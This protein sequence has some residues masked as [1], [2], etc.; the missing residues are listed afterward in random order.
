MS[1]PIF[2]SSAEIGKPNTKRFPLIPIGESTL[3]DMTTYSE[4]VNFI[5]GTAIDAGLVPPSQFAFVAGQI[6]YRDQHVEEVRL[7]CLVLTPA[8]QP[9]RWQ[10]KRTARGE[11]PVASPALVE[12]HE[13]RI[14]LAEADKGRSHVSAMIVPAS[15]GELALAMVWNLAE[16]MQHVSLEKSL[17]TAQKLC[18]PMPHG[19]PVAFAHARRGEIVEPPRIFRDIGKTFTSAQDVRFWKLV[20]PLGATLLLPFDNAVSMYGI[21]IERA[22]TEARAVLTGSLYQ[23]VNIAWALWQ[24]Q[25]RD[26]QGYFRLVIKEAMALLGK[27]AYSGASGGGTF[28]K[29]QTT[30]RR[31][32]DE[33]SRIGIAG[34][35]EVTSFDP[36]PLFSRYQARGKEW[37]RHAAMAVTAVRKGGAF[38]QVPF[39]MLRLS[40]HDMPM[41]TGLAM[42][43]REEIAAVLRGSGGYRTTLRG[44]LEQVGTLNLNEMRKHGRA[45]WSRGAEAVARIMRDGELGE[46]HI[47]G[48]GPSSIAT[49]TP[50]LVLAT[51]YGPLVEAQDSAAIRAVQRADR[52]AIEAGVRK[53]LGQGRPRRARNDASKT[54]R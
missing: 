14:K 48:E 19:I 52:I 15:D 36:E 21:T 41:A 11:E 22:G 5:V 33:A 30:F 3:T 38:M 18:A 28:G 45:Y 8:G 50:S 34:I 10:R 49:L 16:S 46:L 17:E 54:K 12:L 35:G 29:F 20:P 42:L 47:E 25:G 6:F 2:F 9:E 1:H 4:Y 26:E 24:I 31:A 13:G 27:D 32:F 51:V 37:F 23:A 53:K 43:W 40:A 7:S 39:A 44:L